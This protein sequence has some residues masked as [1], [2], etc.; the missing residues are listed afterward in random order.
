MIRM[1]SRLFFWLLT[2]MLAWFILEKLDILPGIDD[3]FRKK[4]VKIDE[5]PIL[6]KEI[7]GLAELATITSFDE[8]V[9]D[10]VYADPA[11]ILLK[12]ITGI[13]DGYDKLVL[14]VSGKVVA[15]TDLSTLTDSSFYVL[16]DSVRLLLPGAEILQVT[17]NPSD[18]SIFREEGKW[19]TDAFEK[20][21]IKAREKMRDR[22]MQQGIIG[23]ADKRSIAIM[24]RFLSQAGFKKVK[25]LL[26]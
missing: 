15:G 1:I 20:V 23:R 5:T 21:K 17:V 18:V 2:L 25:I 8:V 13:G 24:E 22:A 7:R 3:V 14:V 12:S 9:V 10:S 11:G 19:T 6:V 26:L 4:Q 16:K